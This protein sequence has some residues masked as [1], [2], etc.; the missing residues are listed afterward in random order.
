MKFCF[1]FRIKGW[2]R[3][4]KWWAPQKWQTYFSTPYLFAFG[5]GNRLLESIFIV[6][7]VQS[8]M[9][10][11]SVSMSAKVANV[12]VS[13]SGLLLLFFYLLLLLLLN[14]DLHVSSILAFVNVCSN[15]NHY[16][17][18]CECEFSFGQ[19]RAMA[20]KMF[21]SPSGSA[22]FCFFLLAGSSKWINE[23]IWNDLTINK[24]HIIS[25]H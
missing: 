9:E 3:K 8:R 6:A 14:V 4:R 10:K 18:E 7:V 2:W 1:F 11:K 19:S 20:H 12:H 23:R 15:A 25:T 24:M 21:F 22:L 13:F 5:L 16:E 17:C